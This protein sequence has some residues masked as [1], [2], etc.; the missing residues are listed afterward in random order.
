[1]LL[2]NAATD[3]VFTAEALKL[4][5]AGYVAEN[6]SEVDAQA[7]YSVTN[8]L[9][10]NLAKCHEPAFKEV[11]EKFTLIEPYSPDPVSAGSRALANTALGY[12]MANEDEEIEALCLKKLTTADNMTNAGAAFAVLVHSESDLKYQALE[13]FYDKWKNEALV[14]DKWFAVQASSPQAD[15]LRTVKQLLNHPEFSLTNPNRAR[16]V[17]GVFC[18][19]NHHNFH[20]ADGSGYEFAAD[21]IIQLDPAN[22]QLAARIAR[23]F[24]RWRKFDQQ[25]QDHAQRQLQRILDV[26]K[27]SKDTHEV[28]SRALS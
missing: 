8:D 28:I 23:C 10:K 18:H 11:L 3:P 7:I 1:M 4:P 17:I 5:S 2:N 9:Y 26:P 12:L 22:A 15:A 20:A 6:M 14:L 19:G 24:D 16:S 25:H 27:L 21:Q 13:F